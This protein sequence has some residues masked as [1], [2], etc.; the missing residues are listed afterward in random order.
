MLASNGRISKAEAYALL[1][2]N[3]QEL[4]GVIMDDQT[5]DLVAYAGGSMFETSSKVAAVISAQRGQVEVFN[6]T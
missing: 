4:L 3:L 5:G 2:T 6:V 1:S